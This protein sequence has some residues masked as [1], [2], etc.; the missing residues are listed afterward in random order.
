MRAMRTPSADSTAT[1]ASVHRL[2]Q[3]GERMSG[4]WLRNGLKPEFHHRIDPRPWVRAGSSTPAL[5]YDQVKYLPI[6]WAAMWIWQ[7]HP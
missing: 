2:T 1:P 4:R 6:V 3:G 5:H 7:P